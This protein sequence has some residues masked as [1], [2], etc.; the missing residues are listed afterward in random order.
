MERSALP[1]AGE[2]GRFLEAAPSVERE[3]DRARRVVRPLRIE[4]FEVDYRRIT[5][6]SD[7]PAGGQLEASRWA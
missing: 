4:G 1:D 7:A 2:W 5:I 6:E 3:D